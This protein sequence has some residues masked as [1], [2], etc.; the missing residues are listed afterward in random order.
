MKRA[1]LIYNRTA[2]KELTIKLLPRILDRLESHGLET[3]CHATRCP[4][5]AEEAAKE[6]VHR[7]FDVVIAAGGDGTVHEVVNGLKPNQDLPRLGILPCGT[8][9]DLARALQIPKDILR[10]CDV[11]GEGH[12]RPLDVG[13]VQNR[14]FVNVAAAGW[15]TEVTYQAPSRLKTILGQLAYYAKGLEKLSTLLRPFKIRMVTPE[16]IIEEDI[17]LFLVANSSSIGGFDNLVSN[18]S[19]SDGKLDILVIRKTSL[20]HLIQMVGTVLRGEP[21]IDDRII[22][23]QTEKL[24]AYSDE[25]MKLNLDGEWGGDFSGHFEMIPGHVQ[26]FCPLK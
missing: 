23:F 7:G 5:D 6:A 14:L 24:W 22:Q 13:K 8:S 19:V 16:R 2:G 11:I 10:A 3:S 12:V 20:P 9:N 25:K 18:A 4:G 15:M 26:V 17:F 21:L 1:R